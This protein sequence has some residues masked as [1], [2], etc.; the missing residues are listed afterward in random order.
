MLEI[1]KGRK[2]LLM[3]V[4]ILIGVVLVSFSPGN[5]EEDIPYSADSFVTLDTYTKDTEKRLEET[6]SKISGAGETKVMMTFESSFESVYASDARLEENPGNIS[7]SAKTTEKQLVLANDRISGEAPILLKE[8]C[9]KVKGVLVVCSGGEDLQVQKKIK[10]AVSALLSISETKI[11]VSAG[12][13][14]IN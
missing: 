14:V 5:N 13:R 8:L 10:E 4:A 7:A 1:L 12:E 11:Y 2:Q 3:L 6:I 9:P